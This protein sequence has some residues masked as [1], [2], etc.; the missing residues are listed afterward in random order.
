MPTRRTALILSFLAVL[1]GAFLAASADPPRPPLDKAAEKWVQDTLKRM[2]LDEKVGQ[3]LAPAINSVYTPTDSDIEEQ[4]LHLVRDLHVGGIHVFGTAE[5]FPQAMLNP[6]YGNG[7][8]SRKGDPY[9]AA[10]LLNR[11]QQAAK[12]P[13]MTTADFEGG[14]N[15]ILNGGT[16]FPRAMVLG[17]TRD[18][19][20][21][22]RAGQLAATEGRAV[23]VMVDFYPVLDVNNNPRNPII[24]IR[25]FG[26]DVGRVSEMGRAF[27][28]GIQAGGMLATAKH[29]PGHGD[30]NVDTHLGLAVIEHPRDHLDKVELPPFRM[31]VEEGVDAF[32]S[33]HI[34]LP[35]LDPT[36]GVPA[37][38]SRP[39]LTGLLRGE[40]KFDG[41]I[42]TDAMDMYA[43]S[44]N[45]GNAQA[46]MMAVKAGVDFV[47]VI[48]DADA[49]FAAIKAA[50]QS[51]EIAEAQVNA[52]V[53][54]ILRAKAR[55][56][57]H[58]NRQVD[59]PAIATKFGG[60]AHQAAADEMCERGITLLKDERG[61]VPLRVPKDAQVLY[62]S[63]IDYASGWREGAPSRTFIASLKLRWPNV[64]AI[65]VSDRT[66]PSE[67]ELVRALA[68]RADAV[69]AS[70]FV[71][72][73]SYSGRMDL[74]PAQM[75]LLESI[76]ADEKKPFVTV[77][78][79]NPYTAMPLSKL[80]ALLVTYE[81]FDAMEAAAVRA[82][83]GEIP[84]GGKLPITMPGVFPSGTGLAREAIAPRLDARPA[85]ATPSFAPGAARRGEPGLTLPRVLREKKPTYT[86]EAMK[87]KLQGT[88]AMELVVQAD[89]AVGD[90]RVLR[91]LDQTY[92]LDEQA[93]KAVKEWRFA[94]GRKDGKPVAV[95]V[96]IEMTFT[97]K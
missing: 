76:A 64:T 50:V 46:A 27:I 94:P 20:L 67:M 39:I 74:T 41:L 6:N 10:A 68:K 1:S 2:T 62:L 73:A 19:E 61:Q 15:Y 85:Q 69:V 23:G 87:A 34:V 7:S 28:K 49:A 70:V 40:M 33:T 63:V 3:L 55:L 65:E 12:I 31:A 86:K 24:N 14:T 59:I 97:L 90:V 56:G 45:F 18:P 84:I 78:F 5:T 96:E 35:A 92:G 38:L 44:K 25:S 75:G 51:G 37:T 13:L 79:G 48:P 4:K 47:L 53:E 71:R 81:Q 60:R 17:A 89:G 11:L 83:A 57:L 42:F 22:F 32:M 88:V 30:T 36:P 82:V 54:R 16:R 77:L 58:R 72:I 66:T 80:P 93:V 29:F 95:A 21:A 9:A 52:S 43:I 91:S 8:A 26:E